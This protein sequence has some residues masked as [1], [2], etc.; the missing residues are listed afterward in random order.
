MAVSRSCRPQG[1]HPLWATALVYLVSLALLLALRAAVP[2]AA[3]RDQ[4]QLWLLM[5]AAGMTNVGFN[6]AVTVGDVVRVVLLFYLMPAW[7]RAAGLAAAGR[8]ADA[9]AR[10]CAWCWPWPAWRRAA[11]PPAPPGRCPRALADWL[12]L[13]GRLQLRAHQHP[14]ARLHRGAGRAAHPGACSRAAP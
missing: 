13:A 8:E 14:A 1:L 9:A 11:R 4:P 2:G 12:A 6:W 5:A 3:S 7:T 10:C